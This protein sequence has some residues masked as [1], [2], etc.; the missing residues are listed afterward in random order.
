MLLENPGINSV[1]LAVDIA[2]ENFNEVINGFKKIKIFGINITLP[3]KYEIIK[4]IDSMSDEVKVIKS[5]NTIEILPDNKWVGHNTDWFGV[6]KTLELKKID[7]NKKALI[8]GAGGS[9]P[10]VI[11]GLIKYGIT[12]ISITNRTSEK[13]IDLQK[14]FTVKAEDYNDIDKIINNF[15]LII[16]CTTIEFSALIKNNFNSSSLYFDLKYY[17]NEPKIKN[18]IDGKL[19]LLYQGASSFSIWTKKNAPL[20]IMKKAFKW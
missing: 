13:S 11:Y 15:N 20:K 18:Y 14:Q 7:K 17:L 3:F 9:V 1:Y 4:Y 10:A 12:N 8:I 16:N 5:V 19:M 2:L 6:Y